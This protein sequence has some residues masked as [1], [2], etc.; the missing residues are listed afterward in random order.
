MG[1]E[2]GNVVSGVLGYTTRRSGWTR[3]KENFDCRD[4]TMWCGKQEWCETFSLIFM[5]GCAKIGQ[6]GLNWKANGVFVAPSPKSFFF[7][8][9]F[10][11][12]RP[13]LANLRSDEQKLDFHMENMGCPMS[14]HRVS[15]SRSISGESVHG[16]PD[17]FLRRNNNPLLFEL[18]CFS[19]HK[20]KKRHQ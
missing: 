11:Q 18:T 15:T 2:R 14:H 10:G 6:G 1:C 4:I 16:R 9:V 3:P 8:R 20:L 7:L 13:K 12:K 17:F 19:W 5:R